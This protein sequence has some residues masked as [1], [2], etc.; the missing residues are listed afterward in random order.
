VAVVF[1]GLVVV[2]LGFVVLSVQA[3]LLQQMVYLLLSLLNL[4]LVVIVVLRL[5]VSMNLVLMG[6]CVIV[7]LR[8]MGMAVMVLGLMM[9]VRVLVLLR[10]LVLMTVLLGV[11]VLMLMLMSV[12]WLL[13]NFVGLLL[14]LMVAKAYPVK[15]TVEWVHVS[16][17]GRDLLSWSGW[18]RLSGVL[19]WNS[20]DLN[21]EAGSRGVGGDGW[22]RWGWRRLNAGD[23][24]M[25]VVMVVMTMS[26]SGL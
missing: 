11:L 4:S 15:Q 2:R 13:L 10:V 12:L 7:M 17:C 16:L 21:V 25:I 20:H 18:S 24:A 3:E 6:L 22:W 14:L 8:L 9:V 19:S 5:M 26:L 1:V 23:V